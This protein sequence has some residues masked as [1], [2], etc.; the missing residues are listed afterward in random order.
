MRSAILNQPRMDV[1]HHCRFLRSVA[2]ETN[3][4]SLPDD[5]MAK[6]GVNDPNADADGDGQSNLAEYRAG[7]IRLMPHP[8]SKSWTRNASNGHF[9]L[10]WSSVGGVRYRIQYADGDA[11]GAIN[12]TF[13]DIVRS[14]E[15]E[16]DPGVAGAATTQSFTDTFTQTGISTNHVRYYRIKIMP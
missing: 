15:S 10:S 11:S 9:T 7:T 4:N 3:A 14:A 1:Y 16:I 8:F 12:G 2:G 13:T 5:W 6:Y